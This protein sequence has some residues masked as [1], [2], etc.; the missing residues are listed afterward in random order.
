MTSHQILVY[1]FRTFMFGG[2]AFLIGTCAW[3][4]VSMHRMKRE[5]NVA[6]GTLN[7]LAASMKLQ[8]VTDTVQG[9]SDG[10]NGIGAMH[11]ASDL[12]AATDP[13][14]AAV[15]LRT[16]LTLTDGAKKE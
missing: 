13:S 7:A 12:P 16:N 14:V 9:T 6:I 3:V 2:F 8:R 10:V 11:R 1:V 15:E 4:I 5:Q